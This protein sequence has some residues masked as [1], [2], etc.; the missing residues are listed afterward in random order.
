MAL[1]KDFWRKYFEVYDILNEVIPYQ[2]L[3]DTIVK[4]LDIKKGDLVL[5]AGCGTGNLC[6]KLKAKGAKVIGLDNVKEAL[7]IYE[8]K[9]PEAEIVLHDLTEPLPFPDNHFDKIACNNT[10]YTIPVDK[11]SD[12]VKEFYRALKPGGIIVISN[13]HTGFKP[14][15]IYQDHLKKKTD[16][17]GAF[18][19]AITAAKMLAPTVRMFHYNA[20]I[21]KEHRGGSY[22]FVSNDEQT[23]LLSAVEFRDISRNVNVYS[24]Q[25]YLTVGK[26]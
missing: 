23:K 10:L 26:K 18:S 11:R 16:K 6:M 24:N 17:D 13:V 2:E 9:D 7:D 8:K 1:G 19:S 5:E 21:K 3:L 20:Q 22:K 12:V 15:A 4:E 25:A 14:L